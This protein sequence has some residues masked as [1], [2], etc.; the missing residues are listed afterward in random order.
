MKIKKL[1][2]H[3]TRKTLLCIF[4]LFLFGMSTNAQLTTTRAGSYSSMTYLV[5]KVLLGSGVTATNITYQGIDTSFGLFRG[6]KS[7]IGMD[8]G[9]IITNGTIT[10]CNG[11]NV[12]TS[13]KTNQATTTYNTNG[14]TAS[15]TY[16]DSDLA[17][18]IGTTYANTYSCAILQFD[19]IANSDSIEFQYSFGSN[20]EPYYVGSKYL[21]DFGFFLSG[22]GIAGPFSHGGINLALI[23]GTNTAVYINSVNCTT[24]PAYYVCN[25][26]STAGCSTCPATVAATTVGYNGFTTV[27]TAKAKVQCGKKYHIKLGVADI[28]NGKFDSGV[29]LKAGSFKPNV[30]P[31]TVGFTSTA[32]CAGNPA[33][34]SAS[35]AVSYTW[36]PAI[37]LNTT[38]GSSVIA[39][40]TVT[41]T[42]TVLGNMT[43]GCDDTAKIVVTVP[44][45]PTLSVTPSAPAICSSG[46]VSLLAS[47]ASSYSWTPSAG[48]TCTNCPNPIAS[49]TVTTKYYITGTSSSGC[50]SKDSVTINVAASLL[51]TVTPSV[52]TVCNGDSVLLNANGA[53]S[54][55]WS[56]STGLTCPT[57][58]STYANTGGAN[59]TYTVIGSSGGCSN[60]DSV[61]ISVNPTPTITVNASTSS[62]CSGTPTTLT[63]NGGITYTW[64][65]AS[66]LNTTTGSPVTATP[67]TAITYIVKGID[68]NGCSSKDSIKISINPTPTLTLTTSTIPVICSGNS[69][70]IKASGASTY[71]WS[72]ASSLSSSTDSIVNA[73]PPGTITYTLVGTSSLGCNDT[74]HIT[75]FVNPTPTLSVTPPNPGICPGDSVLLVASGADIYSWNP[76][77]GLDSLSVDSIM[78]KPATSTTYTVTGTTSGC[79]S[80]D[81]VS[82]H[83][84]NLV[85]TANAISSTLCFGDS[86]KITAGGAITY[87]WNPSLG[88]S[89]TTGTTVTV[90]P[91]I[92][93]TYS[94]VGTSG[95][96]CSDSTTITITVNPTP[97]L[98]LSAG[99]TM[100]CFGTG[101]TTITATGVT[102]Y[103]WSPAGS[104]NCST[105]P[106]PIANPGST[107]TYTVTGTSALGCIS[108]DTISIV[109]DKP[110]ITASAS[111]PTICS[112]TS[113]SIN[114]LGGVS[115]TWSPA[116]SLSTSTGSSVISNPT[117][118]TTYTVIGIDIAG[119]SDSTN[120]VVTVNQT[121]SVTAS[122]KDSS[123]CTGN[124][125][126][127]TGSGANSYSWTPT[128]GL[129]C[130]TCATT[131]ASPATST[132]YTLI[133]TSSAGC[134]DT[135]YL[136]ITVNTSPN[137][138]IGL[139]PNN[140]TLCKGIPVTITATG[141]TTYTWKPSNGLNQTTGST[142]TATIQSSPVIYTVIGS[143]GT[144]S[145]S[146]KQTLYL[147][148]PL[149]VTM[150]PDSICLGK[151][152][153]VSISVS[154]G[155]P[156]YSYA[157]NNNFSNSPGPFMVSPNSSTY[158]VCNVTDGCNTSLKD[159]M[160]V[161]TSPVPVAKFTAT[162][163]NIWGGQ[164]ISFVNTSSGAT[165]YYWNLGG[166]ASSVDSFP[167]YQY[168]IP[169]SYIVY[170]IAYNQFGCSD[171]ASDTIT[172]QGGI[173]VPNVFTPNDDGQNDVFHVTAGGMQ[174]YTIE[175]F[176][177]WGQKVF[178]TNSPN[179]D[180]TGKSMSGV[181]ESDGTYFYLI[182]AT[183]YNNKT[184]NLKGYLE[185]IR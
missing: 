43:G 95:S 55:S 117:S 158:Y 33:T 59:I 149:T 127:L 64:S 167:Y 94:V 39:T 11:P 181:D 161:F 89:S 22:P 170:L 182:N 54:F 93:T 121:P 140:D 77:T 67:T 104:L 171:T 34:L 96:G 49:P 99:A 116:S 185:L 169:G 2:L 63:A 69:D 78:A 109:V 17:N 100:I 151:T 157:W 102:G 52:S 1:Q 18:L 24:N 81:T 123:I 112:G 120:V 86:T 124:S 98:S 42:Y 4:P 125:T 35:G 84:G 37:S 56:P 14:W 23:P 40:P 51:V 142:V 65:P 41:T 147:Y 57:C 153:T 71:L 73:N 108:T 8:S 32:T 9:L 126:S 19:F 152:S 7:N 175:I 88:L 80:T 25:W 91:T 146:A 79:S 44:A 75:M 101:G 154:G 131:N 10:N 31:M 12:K 28:A 85:V 29:F 145:D 143:N 136:P 30:A 135:A 115:Y 5:N 168:N 36:S 50:T 105:C 70:T 173:I 27:L 13:D 180:W 129:N 66:E 61:A 164:F 132:T 118:A 159:S 165:S 74:A 177:R 16:R 68:I 62:V 53:A 114:A 183:D 26:P 21:D 92:T 20:E 133:G 113:T 97:T 141:G 107:T 144:C 134:P 156:G 130:A 46:S 166:G 172:V 162:P 155:K 76:I 178:E 184:Y 174:T 160:Q 87:A 148:P 128:S 60:K 150:N 106:N 90:T 3:F 103:L 163:E 176:N 122:T 58:P 83:V 15:N 139:S 38:T 111:T 47:G 110:S 179:I 45:N 138:S 48:L 82:I 72:P 137:I 119:C 6:T